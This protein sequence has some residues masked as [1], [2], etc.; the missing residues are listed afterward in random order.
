MLEKKNVVDQ[1]EITR[2]GHI[3]VRRASLILED[4]VEIAKSYHRHVLAPGDDASAEDSK[5]T[6]IAE[7]VWTPEVVKA[8]EDDQ[9]VQA[10]AITR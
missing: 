3:Q 6:S 4:G 5:V 2:D 7:V 9:V 1:I 10:E 8:Y